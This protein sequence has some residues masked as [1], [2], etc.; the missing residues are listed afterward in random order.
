MQGG[1]PDQATGHYIQNDLDHLDRH[2]ELVIW[3]EVLEIDRKTGA[4][5]L[6]VVRI[7]DGPSVAV[8]GNCVIPNP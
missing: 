6:Q 2:K 5:V 1:W 3:S 7:D 4:T 8:R